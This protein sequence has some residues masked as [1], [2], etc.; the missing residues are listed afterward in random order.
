MSAL[1]DIADE[2]E[3]NSGCDW[4]EFFIQRYLF[5]KA[6]NAVG[7]VV[8]RICTPVLRCVAAAIFTRRRTGR[9][10]FPLGIVDGPLAMIGGIVAGVVYLGYRIDKTALGSLNKG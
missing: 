7:H 8:A 6:M 2:H 10:Y 9:R 1:A 3:L 4:K 5:A